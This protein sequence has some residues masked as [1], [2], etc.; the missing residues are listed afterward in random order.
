MIVTRTPLRIGL[1]GGGTDLPEYSNKYGGYVVSAT[2]NKF[3]YVI[4]NKHLC[5][6]YIIRYSREEIVPSVD[7][8][9][10]PIFREVLKS[11]EVKPEWEIITYADVPAGTGLG[12]SSSFTV[13][14]LKAIT[15]KNK[16][17]ILDAEELARKAIYI[18]RVQLKEAGG[19]QDQY[20]AAYGGIRELKIAENGSV[21]VQ[22]LSIE[23]DTRVSLEKR[24]LMFYTGVQRRSSDI[25]AK[26][27]R[28]VVA[29][30]GS[31]DYLHRTK[32]I[33][34]ESASALQSGNLDYYGELMDQ[35]WQI[36]KAMSKSISSNEID[37]FYEIGK[38]NGALGGKVIGAGGGGFLLFYVP[39]GKMEKLRR[40]MAS[41]GLK[42]LPFTFANSGSGSL[43]NYEWS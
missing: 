38:T 32:E 19:I 1:A 40:E 15:T 41:W 9:Q 23:L 13:G 10:H 4:M 12:S 24:L 14:L 43:T 36:K 34:L 39:K 31:I 33:G 20:I 30:G 5:E 28:D 8:I 7:K 2:I 27:S 25:Q 21:N 16:G 17:P 22:S 3:I 29:A 26:V 42:E 11:F 35:N 6:H 18:E 37:N